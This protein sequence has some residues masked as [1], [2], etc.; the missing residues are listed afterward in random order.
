MNFSFTLIQINGRDLLTRK[1][2]EKLLFSKEK[3]LPK[4]TFFFSIQLTDIFR[5]H[6]LSRQ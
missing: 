1:L 2:A 5:H 3:G 4:Q 6:F